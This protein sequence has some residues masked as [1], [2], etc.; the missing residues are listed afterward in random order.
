MPRQGRRAGNPCD[1]AGGKTRIASVSRGG[2]R[3]RSEKAFISSLLE[4]TRLPRR[5]LSTGGTRLRDVSKQTTGH[6]PG[7][8]RVRPAR[9]G[10]SKYAATRRA[11]SAHPRVPGRVMRRRGERRVH[12]LGYLLVLRAHPA[13]RRRRCRTTTARASPC[14]WRCGG[15]SAR[16]LRCVDCPDRCRRS[17][18]RRTGRSAPAMP[19]RRIPPAW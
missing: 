6:E 3:S 4:A 17:G 19:P 2:E 5:G 16:P 15:A 10:N 14:W 18:A 8:G 9:I 12:Q 1:P 11:R 7:V 13:A